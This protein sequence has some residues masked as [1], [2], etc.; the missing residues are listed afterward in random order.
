M[1][2]YLAASQERLQHPGSTHPAR[3]GRPTQIHQ[4]EIPSFASAVYNEVMY[5]SPNA[6]LHYGH[7]DMGG[8]RAKIGTWLESRPLELMQCQERWQ[9][10]ASWATNANPLGNTTSPKRIM[11]GGRRGKGDANPRDPT[12]RCMCACVHIIISSNPFNACVLV[13]IL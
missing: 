10:H 9:A 3:L 13:Y 6:L 7:A 12:L 1:R 4:V 5:P 2:M 11:K 8:T